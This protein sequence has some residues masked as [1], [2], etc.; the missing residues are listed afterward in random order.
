LL[1]LLLAFVAPVFVP[2]SFSPSGGRRD[3]GRG[4]DQGDGCGSA[5]IAKSPRLPKH[6]L[7]FQYRNIEI[8]ASGPWAVIG[9]LLLVVAI[10]GAIGFKAFVPPP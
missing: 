5:A 7:F 8:A 10:G 4:A 6:R 2:S 3:D 1:P 9:L